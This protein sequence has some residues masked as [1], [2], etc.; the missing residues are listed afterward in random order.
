MIAEKAAD[1]ILN[2]RQRPAVAP[3]AVQAEALEAHDTLRAQPAPA[4]A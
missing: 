1:V 4:A 2:A 3:P